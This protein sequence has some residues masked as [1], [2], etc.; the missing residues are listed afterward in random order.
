M[1]M[2]LIGFAAWIA[3]LIAYVACLSL[4]WRQTISSGDLPAVLFWSASVSALAVAFVY[5]PAMFA[6]QRR[7]SGTAALWT[8]A[9]SS[10]ALGIVPVLLLML[11]FGGGLRSTP[12]AFLFYCMFTAFGVVFGAGFSLVYGHPR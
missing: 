6:L 10:A 3:G 7:T 11:I 5:A 1:R 4:L 8:Y 2:A 9:T 12:E